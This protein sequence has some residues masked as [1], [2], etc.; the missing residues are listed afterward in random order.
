[1]ATTSEQLHNKQPFNLILKLFIKFNWSRS[2]AF[3]S[4]ANVTS[5][6]NFKLHSVVF[7]NFFWLFTTESGFGNRKITHRYLVAPFSEWV[8]CALW[9]LE[10]MFLAEILLPFQ[11][12]NF[13][14]EIRKKSV[15]KTN[16]NNQILSIWYIIVG[17]YQNDIIGQFVRLCNSRI[18]TWSSNA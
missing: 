6:M 15:I 1:M 7:C 8:H 12:G 5:V 11:S 3:L 2:W 13:L 18:C 14:L 17:W 10:E 4:E 9:K 16:S